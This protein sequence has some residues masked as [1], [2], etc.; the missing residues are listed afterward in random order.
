MDN[1]NNIKISPKQAYLNFREFLISYA[2]NI[3][4]FGPTLNFGL[5]Q[6]TLK[7]FHKYQAWMSSS[8]NS[9]LWV[10]LNFWADS[11]SKLRCPDD[12]CLCVCSASET[13]LPCWLETS[14]QIAYDEL[15]S[16][17]PVSLSS[18]LINNDNKE[19]FNQLLLAAQSCSFGQ[20]DT[21]D[22]ENPK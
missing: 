11:V 13:P 20:N 12:V 16:L 9:R 22:I 4:C 3:G 6:P 19:L 17:T 18:M 10:T 2:L 15:S 8:K 5:K 14:G 1:F 7:A 21:L